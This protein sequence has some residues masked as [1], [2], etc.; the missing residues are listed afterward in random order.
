MQAEIRGKATGYERSEDQ[1]TGDELGALRYVPFEEGLLRVIQA[2]L[3]HNTG[4]G[5]QLQDLLAK[6]DFKPD[7]L[8]FWQRFP[9]PVKGKKVEPDLVFT[10]TD[11]QVWIEVKYLSGLSGDGNEAG[12]EETGE[13][14]EATLNQLEKQLLA[15]EMAAEGK[16]AF[17]ILLA[18]QSEAGFIYHGTLERLEAKKGKNKKL[19]QVALGLLTW[20]KVYRVVNA[21]TISSYTFPTNLIFKDLEAL[22]CRK[23]FNGFQDFTECGKD[24][25]VPAKGWTFHCC[26]ASFSFSYADPE[27]DSNLH[28][29]FK[30]LCN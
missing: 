29:K 1:L 3:F 17:L 19:G 18:R 11:F 22:L 12:D 25:I 7:Q 16:P 24:E 30:L 28:F 4:H 13:D 5:T 15:L 8:S 27:I 6:A 20:E 21:S 26:L 10:F 2:A 9:L 14:L 23:G